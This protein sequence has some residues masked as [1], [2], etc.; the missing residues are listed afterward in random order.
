MSN[1]E[2][3]IYRENENLNSTDLDYLARTMWAEARG[4]GKLGMKHVGSVVLNRVGHRDFP[5]SVRE[6]VLQRNQFYVWQ[7]SLANRT[8]NIPS[9]DPLFRL[10]LEAARE[11]LTQG[12]INTYLFFE[13][14]NVKKNGVVIGNHRFR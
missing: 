14:K 10:A 12:P 11:L 9:D 13:H 1:E 2:D 7:G 8:R 3:N 4:E 6:V 5:S